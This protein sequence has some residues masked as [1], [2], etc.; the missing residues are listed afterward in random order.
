VPSVYWFVY[1]APSTYA[2]GQVVTL[3]NTTPGVTIR[4]TTNGQD[5]TT[6]DPGLTSGGTI[7]VGNF[8]LK[9]AAFRAGLVPSAVTVA[10][11]VKDGDSCTY[12]FSPRGLHGGPR[13]S[14]GVLTVQTNHPGC[15]WTATSDLPWV[16]LAVSEGI[17]NGQIPYHMAANTATA[18]EGVV[19][20]GDR[21]IGVTQDR[22]ANCSADIAPRAL[23]ITS[24]AANGVLTLTANDANCT[25]AATSDV[26]W[27]TVGNS[28][29]NGPYAAAV[30]SDH[31]AGYWRLSDPAAS[32][33]AS[34]AS[35]FGH[36][37]T[38]GGALVLGQAGP[39]LENATTAGF[40]GASA[41]IQIPHAAVF[42]VSQISWEAWVNVP[43]VSASSRRLLGKGTGNELFSL[44]VQPNMTQATVAWSVVG[45]G[46]QSAT[47]DAAIVGAGWTHVAFTYDGTTWRAYVNGV[48]D[49]SGTVTGTLV[50]TTDA[51]VLGSNG[52][53]EWFDGGLA[54][55]AVYPY[56]LAA[57]QVAN[58]FAQRMRVGIG[59]T[60]LTYA[61]AANDS[62]A[63]R[64]GA[65][66]VAGR[67]IP[68]SQAAPGGVAV[69]AELSPTANLAG[70]N[71]SDVVVSF[72]CAGEGVVT[73]PDPVTLDEEG[74]R[75]VAGTA[76][77]DLWA[78]AT[79][80]IT[81][82][83]D[84]TP[85]LVSITS[86]TVGTP[87]SPGPLTV[88]GIAADAMSEASATCNGQPAAEVEAGFSCEVLVP[89]GPSS[90]VVEAV[91][92]AGN[93][94][95]VTV[96]VDT[97]DLQTRPPT[98]LRVTP[99]E[100]TLVL[101]AKRTF[102]VID[103]LGRIPMDA[104]WSI[105]D[106]SVATLSSAQ[107]PLLTA[108]AAGE[109]TLRATWRGLSAVARIKVLSV[110]VAPSGTILWSASPPT[111][112]ATTGRIV[113]GTTLDGERRIYAVE[114]I[115]DTATIR[116]F[117]G[118][119]REIWSASAGGRVEQLS[120][121]SIGGAV[122]S[123]FDAD[124]QVSSLQVYR[125]DG[126][127]S[128]TPGPYGT[129]AIHPKGALYHVEG[130]FYGGS[131]LQ[132]VDIGFGAGPSLALPNGVMNV[133]EGSRQAPVNCS[134]QAVSWGAG[135]PTVL[136]DGTVV[137]PVDTSERTFLGNG[138]EID[139]ESWD[140]ELRLSVVFLRP[141]GTSAL[142]TALVADA[143]IR[144]QSL[145]PFKAIPNGQGGLLVGYNWEE[146]VDGRGSGVIVV[147]ADGSYTAPV[148][149]GPALQDLALGEDRV[150]AISDL[151]SNGD[152]RL[153]SYLTPA[154]M[155]TGSSNL[156]PE[157]Q[158]VTSVTALRGGGFLTSLSDGTVQGA[159]DGSDQ[160]SLAHARIGADNTLIGA[161]A[162]QSLASVAKPG[163]VVGATEWTTETGTREGAEFAVKPYEVQVN[164]QN[165][166]C[167]S[168]N[169]WRVGA[170]PG[171]EL[172]SANEV[173]LVKG[174]AIQ[175][176]N[177]AY[178]D[179]GYNVTFITTVNPEAP[180]QIYVRQTV[181]QAARDPTA[182]GYT[183]DFAFE[184][185][186]YLPNIWNALMHVVDCPTLQ[187]DCLQ[188]KGRTREQVL[189]AFGKGLGNTA[190]HELGHQAPY[191]FTAHVVSC[192]D[193]YDSVSSVSNAHF[194]GQLHWSDFAKRKM[195]SLLK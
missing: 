38:V 11:Y 67:V 103:D 47:L 36:T 66:T 62:G 170:C 65:L 101:G 34:D 93:T 160:L 119:G 137:V 28:T 41:S 71:N 125:P 77:N 46:R 174:A 84:R 40:D 29:D 162:S 52:V 108:A 56:A 85:P 172:L 43:A 188:K 169:E 126:G 26:P 107:T 179:Q 89:A 184:S 195:R 95:A 173:T 59:H 76:W 127:A 78:E 151:E 7:V 138:I 124:T 49:G 97:T 58:H 27:V 104:V 130:D 20:V 121:D 6:T 57:D 122:A 17:G 109:T 150:I 149:A 55:V 152:R 183:P 135:T 187:G 148:G 48:E 69:A 50:S 16:T 142:Q 21:H 5:P 106:E 136:A 143:T 181:R 72:V 82:R 88:R 112:G 157:T 51:L 14:G 70:W 24:G 15:A 98:S 168:G 128:T 100:V 86:P 83:L 44:S 37:G 190:A 154:G 120:V 123:V 192:L 159:G 145:R 3:T 22:A 131:T 18:R 73:C 63:T 60:E 116:A 186:V 1:S 176:M 68:I 32:P 114:Q 167:G 163:A 45:A 31:P 193:C 12:S 161:L 171:G 110:V 53:D 54:E 111:G 177:A 25:W 115:G 156:L 139:N 113:Q 117:H 42:N 94:R 189:R 61:V 132:S 74:V 13:P 194:F 175:A 9:A 180:R 35:G 2:P 153:M 166:Y 33:T 8:T 64:T 147:N 158:R 90:I 4:Y 185:D 19:T 105:D 129:F 118:D 75:D 79:T 146:G 182:V 164:F 81:V 155:P 165:G 178:R 92:Q 140:V 133:C 91:D 23:A 30:M 96:D 141:D 102:A 39:L 10:D 87:V 144:R 80:S 99:G 191:Y 134:S